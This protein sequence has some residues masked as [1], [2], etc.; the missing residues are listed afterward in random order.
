MPLPDTGHVTFLVDC[1]TATCRVG[2]GPPNHPALAIRFTQP[3]R[4]NLYMKIGCIS[5]TVIIWTLVSITL[6]LCEVGK[7]AEFPITA[8]PWNWSCLCILYWVAI[9]CAAFFI[10]VMAFGLLGAKR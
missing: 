1:Y 3:Y 6:S 4:R 9:A 7:F 8:W 2:R 5:T 10:G